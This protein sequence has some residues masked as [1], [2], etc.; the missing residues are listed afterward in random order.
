MILL[1][2]DWRFVISVIVPE[3]IHSVLKA[4]KE[5]NI[6]WYVMENQVEM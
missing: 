6:A 1:Q 4:I 3:C 2:F 5:L